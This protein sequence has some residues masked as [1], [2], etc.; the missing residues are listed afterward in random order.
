MSRQGLLIGLM[1]LVMASP[2]AAEDKTNSPG[3]ANQGGQ[4]RAAGG[5]DDFGYVF[6]DTAE[7]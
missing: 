3:P 1:V 5:P 6:M 2:L 7:G 4:V